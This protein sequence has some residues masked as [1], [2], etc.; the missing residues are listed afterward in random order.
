M[1]TSD[2]DLFFML[3]YF[4]KS[5]MMIVNMAVGFYFFN[6]LSVWRWG[7]STG[8]GSSLRSNR[9][10]KVCVNRK[11]VKKHS[12]LTKTV[13]LVFFKKADPYLLWTWFFINFY[14]TCSV[15][16]IKSSGDMDNDSFYGS[17]SLDLAN[18]LQ[19]K[20]IRNIL[21]TLQNTNH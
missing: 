20:Q 14:E 17:P 18:L 12:F 9:S 19:L 4:F 6:W 15:R 5:D 11:G 21:Q 7:N 10:F 13:S 8:P 1:K 3:N 16:R 2:G